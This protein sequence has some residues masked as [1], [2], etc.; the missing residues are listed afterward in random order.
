MPGREQ[1]TGDALTIRQTPGIEMFTVQVGDRP[2]I[3]ALA[4]ESLRVYW[5]IAIYYWGLGK[6]TLP[7]S[8]F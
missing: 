5:K 6:I 4:S 1:G 7:P 3:P 8:S 2:L